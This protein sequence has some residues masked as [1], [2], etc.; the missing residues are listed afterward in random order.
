MITESL[1]HGIQRGRIF[2]R[3][4]HLPFKH[5]GLTKSALGHGV[6]ALV[7]LISYLCTVRCSILFLASALPVSLVASEPELHAVEA[8]IRTGHHG[9]SSLRCRNH[10][11]AEILPCFLKCQNIFPQKRIWTSMCEWAVMGKTQLPQ[12]KTIF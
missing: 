4:Q 9:H 10:Q 12:G 5:W 2:R 11:L 6:L 8:S 7:F 1:P 3:C